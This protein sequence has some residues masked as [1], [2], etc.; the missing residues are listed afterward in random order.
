M[1]TPSPNYLSG[2]AATYQSNL[3]GGKREK[4]RK[5]K[6]RRHT[7]GRKTMNRNSKRVRIM[8]PLL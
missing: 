7:R 5:S 3:V 8:V 4:K 1:L 6:R 2:D